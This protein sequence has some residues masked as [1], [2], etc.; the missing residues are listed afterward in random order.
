M[1]NLI[2]INKEKYATVTQLGI[3]KPIIEGFLSKV[4]VG[5]ALSTS[6]LSTTRTP[7]RESPFFALR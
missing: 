4:G 1:E 3:S 7:P 2:R 5:L 6:G